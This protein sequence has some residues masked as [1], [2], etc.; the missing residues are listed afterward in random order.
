MPRRKRI[1]YDPPHKRKKRR[2]EPSSG[3]ALQGYISRRMLIAK[4]GVV[5]VFA[6]LAAKLGEMQV[7]KG[8][9]FKKQAED[10]VLFSE[11][12]QPAR[13]LILD[14][15]GR[16]LAENRRAWEVRVVPAELPQDDEA[17]RQRVLD[18]LSSELGLGDV[19]VINPSGVPKGSAATVYS[20]VARMIYSASDEET[21]AAKVAAWTEEAETNK[22]VLVSDVSIDDAALVRSKIA[23]LPG[24]SV[25]NEV[26]YLVT[27]IWAPERPVT[28]KTDVP[29]DV[30]LRLESNLMYL[31]GVIMDSNA[32]V[33]KYTGGEIMS[34]VIGFVRNIDN[35]GLNSPEN[36]DENKEPIYDQTDFIGSEGL[37]QALEKMLRGKKGSR[38]VERDVNGVQ[39]RVL[40]E[41]TIEPTPG[42]NVRLS[43]DLEF[44]EAVGKALK[45]QIDA[46]AEFKRQQNVERASEGKREWAIPNAGAVVAF[47]PRNGE[48][49]A[50]VSYPYYDNQLFATGISERKFREYQAEDRGTPFLN[51]C[52]NELYPPG[53][54]FKIFLAASALQRGTLTP[55]QTHT[56]QGAIQVPYS[57]DITEGVPMACWV[58]WN[59]NLR[60]HGAL[61]LLEAIERS[62]DVYF[63][64]VA[65]SKTIDRYS[66]LP[67]YYLDYNLLAGEIVSEEEHIFNGLGI[68]PLAEDMKTRF[69]FGKATEIEIIEA[70]GLFPDPDW[71][72]DAI[73]GEE[74]T[75]GETL[76]VSIG[77][78]ETKAT[79]LQLT[80][81]TAALANR[82]KIVRP[83]LVHSTFDESGESAVET[84]VMGDVGVSKDKLDVVIEGMRRVV[85]EETGTAH[86]SRINEQNVSKWLLTNP[87]GEED[88]I[89]IA[90]KTGT[91]EFGEIDDIGARDTHAW[92]TCFAPLEA[93]EIA[94]SVVIEAGGE[95]S[96]YAV[97]VADE[98]L[99]AYF[100]LTGRRQR[101]KVLSSDPL[102]SPDDPP[103]DESTPAAT[104]NA[105]PEADADPD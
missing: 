74:W 27:N 48:V 90:G 50:M 13:G 104:P 38:T 88:V 93:P 12:I 89:T 7:R 29:R 84:E 97:P 36:L 11:V 72:A 22:L 9:S 68:E 87:E 57:T 54:T 98:V 65:V 60:P 105:T 39:V 80:L 17:A 23:E 10:N 71:K 59:K 25:V 8:E 56:C 83:H 34:H 81:N 99:R 85:H 77:Q 37:E 26:E 43:I 18:S 76:N 24:V 94:I 66:D 32:L 21:Q 16:T 100:E 55:E 92:F 75:V 51:R 91:A 67:I 5:G 2:R 47:D 33:R 69:W 64:N 101:G 1:Q 4:A 49:L 30:A 103:K 45:K 53:S 58:G 96:T 44:Q 70:E 82:G 61:N 31:P 3:Q 42:T 28:I 52:T 102:P 46:A 79:P 14:R 19:L 6:V 40:R 78:G 62:C 15:K 41:G 63:Y 20:R 35:V 73:P 95:G 86:H